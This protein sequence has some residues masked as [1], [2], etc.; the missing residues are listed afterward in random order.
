[1]RTPKIP[2]TIDDSRLNP[3]MKEK[4]CTKRRLLKRQIQK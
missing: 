2:E 1:L 4:S 3:E